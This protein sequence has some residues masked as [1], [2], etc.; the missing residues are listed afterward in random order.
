MKN[1][2]LGLLV[3]F[4]ALT[5]SPAGFIYADY[6]KWELEVYLEGPGTSKDIVPVLN[7]GVIFRWG[8]GG[9]CSVEQSWT[10]MESELTIE[11]KTLACTKDGKKWTSPLICRDNRGGRL[12]NR[13]LELYPVPRPATIMFELED[14]VNSPFLRFR[15]FF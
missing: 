11:G 10:R 6:F 14:P 15:C 5:A 12:Y 13:W 9:E 7:D 4:V 3:L 1:G 2:W 8:K